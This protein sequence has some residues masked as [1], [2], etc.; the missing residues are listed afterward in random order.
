MQTHP[1]FSHCMR[2]NN[3]RL[4]FFY[5]FLNLIIQAQSRLTFDMISDA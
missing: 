4:M 1:L 5:Y 3:Q 2:K